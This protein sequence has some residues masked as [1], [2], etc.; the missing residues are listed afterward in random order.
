MS[1]FASV[2]LPT[3]DRACTLP[4][5]I[6]SVLNQTVRDIELIIVGDGCTKQVREICQLWSAKDSR[7][8]FLDLEKA[9]NRGATNRDFGVRSARSNR[10]FYIDDDDLFLPHHIET[11]GLELDRLDVV[12]T[13]PVSIGPEGGISLGII[14][15]GNSLQK[16]LLRE[17]KFKGVFDTHLAH[18]KDIYL[19][20]SGA[21]LN[22]S[23]HRVVLHMLK[24]FA[25]DE[26]KWETILR[27]TALSFHGIRRITMSDEN[28]AMELKQWSLKLGDSD[29]EAELQ[30]TGDYGHHV[31][32]LLTVLH[33]ENYAFSN[34][35][36]YLNDERGAIIFQRE[37]TSQ[38]LSLTK[39]QV[40]TIDGLTKLVKGQAV[41][42]NALVI[43]YDLLFRPHLGPRFFTLNL[44]K[45]LGAFFSLEETNSTSVNES[46]WMVLSRF[47]WRIRHA[48]DLEISEVEEF[49]C[50]L[51][52]YDAFFGAQILALAYRNARKSE[53]SLRI[54]EM[55]ASKAP[56]HPMVES[57][58]VMKNEL[59]AEVNQTE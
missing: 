59:T 36:I 43:L 37:E 55:I 31:R 48:K 23:D 42:E 54:I 21:W 25:A 20:L 5:A 22:A 52:D 8:V 6:Q 38:E 16:K 7:V 17:E 33:E 3:H 15:S 14:N 29:L 2:I 40:I 34:L 45:S 13:P 44:L 1:L 51:P 18:T 49:V 50:N 26:V 56:D 32:T 57:F 58:W 24:T 12:D 47:A 30:R 35:G 19:E 39:R 4:Y 27:V 46:H 28:R 10:I 9:P 53:S 41:S 11:L